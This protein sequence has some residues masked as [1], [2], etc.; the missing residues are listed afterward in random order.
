MG[1]PTDLLTV[2]DEQDH[3]AGRTT[4]T[5]W[6]TCLKIKGARPRAWCTRRRSALPRRRPSKNF[7]GTPWRAF[8]V[9]GT[10][11]ARSL[12]SLFPAV[13][14][15]TQRARCRADSSS[16]CAVTILAGLGRLQPRRRCR[17]WVCRR[18]RAITIQ[19]VN[20]GFSGDGPAT[21]H[22]RTGAAGAGGTI[23]T[24]GTRSAGKRHRRSSQRH[25]LPP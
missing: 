2:R 23:A 1:V 9:R 17:Q 7:H 4:S 19:R 3:G 20:C 8:C 24:C 15:T 25:D 10:T 13:L 21:V 5:S 18:W 6:K 14:S 22:S 11:G 16:A 12:T